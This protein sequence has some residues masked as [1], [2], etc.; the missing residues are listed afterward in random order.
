MPDGPEMSL[1]TG[2][3]VRMSRL[4][5]PGSCALGGGSQPSNMAMMT[6]G[7]NPP[8]PLPL[9]AVVSYVLS[10]SLPW[11]LVSAFGFVAVSVAVSLVHLSTAASVS[12]STLPLPLLFA[13]VPRLGLSTQVCHKLRSLDT[14]Q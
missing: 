6:V 11:S 14:E 7:G 10:P 1:L 9:F 8:C 2:L 13:C 3:D 5:V 4:A 12:V